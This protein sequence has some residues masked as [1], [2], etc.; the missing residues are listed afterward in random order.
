MQR[1]FWIKAHLIAAA[2]FTPA[3][4]LVAISG[5]LYLLGIKG[6]ITQTPVGVAQQQSLNPQ[7]RELDTEVAALLRSLGIEPDFEYVKVSGS[8]LYTRPTSEP[9]YELRLAADRVTVL[10]NQPSLQKSLI[11]LHK[12]H[13]PLMFKDFQK[14][15]AVML[16]FILLSGTWLG[17]A[18]AGLRL[19]TVA[20]FG[21][22]LA[23]LLALILAP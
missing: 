6:D 20:A 12:G 11:E 23:V 3:L 21:S 13:G 10:H 18:S 15:L 16:L 1:S 5:G 2:F 8:T 17:L 22:G 19:T 14:A 7:S 9:H 4:L